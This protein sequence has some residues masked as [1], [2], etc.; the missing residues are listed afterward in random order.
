MDAKQ[1]F[2]ETSNEVAV[3]KLLT[4]SVV[5]NTNGRLPYL[6]RVLNSLMRQ[7][8]E[9]F[10]VCVV[11]GPTQDGTL[12]YLDSLGDRI[13][14]APCEAFNLSVSRNVGIAISAGDIIA[15]I[16][17]DS[18]AEPEWLLDLVAAYDD[19]D[20]GAAGGFVYDHTGTTFQAGYVTTN[21][22]GY[23]T[24]WAEPSPH[25]NFPLSADYPHL[26][27]TNCSFRRSALLEI[28]GF[29]NEFEYFLDETD[30]C[31]RLNDAGYSILQLSNGFVHHKY[32]PSHMRDERRIV[33]SWYPLI[34]NRVY[35]GIRNG[36]RHHS[37]REI[38]EA[39]LQDVRSW[40][41]SIDAAAAEGIYSQN[42]IDRFTAEADQAVQD[43][44]TRGYLAPSRL[45]DELLAH[46]KS[47]FKKFAVVSPSGS[48]KTFCFVTQDYP[49]DQNGGIARNISQL[50]RTLAEAGH[51]VHVLTKSRGTSTVDY[52]D[53]AWV[54]RVAI[55]H[56]VQ[57]ATSPI[58]PL[59]VPPHIWN[60]GQT[61][62]EEVNKI[63]KKRRVDVVYCPL[64]DCEPLA[65]VLDGSLPLIV[66]LQTTMKF[67][68]DSQ[69]E[70]AS[71]QA[72]MR[73]YGLPIIA[74]EELILKNAKVLHGNSR[75][76]VRDIEEKYGWSLDASKIYYSPHG[77]EDWSI[78]G[79][80]KGPNDAT[81]VHVLFVGRLESRKGI[82]VLLQA[83]P[84]I[85]S[86]YP[87]TVF[88]IVGDDAILK[89]DGSSY[90]ED[91]LAQTKDEELLEKVI[92]HGK[93]GEDI[94]RRFYAGCDIFVAPSRYESFGLVFLEAMMF[95]KPVIG[96]N[97]GGGPEVVTE[98]VSGF[99]VNP[100]DVEGLAQSL[101]VL[102]ANAELR[103]SMGRSAR[104]DY[105]SRFTDQVMIRD[106][107]AAVEMFFT[108]PA[109]QIQ[110]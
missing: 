100:G 79:E 38:I 39:G 1:F 106:M 47:A 40:E 43:A 37:L 41:R 26:L 28:G 88:D 21:R 22:L 20:V 42:D 33:K 45:T 78:A 72:W 75:A 19:E 93:V 109:V 63:Q 46:H 51:Q 53:G 95:G 107:Y 35:F 4:V 56:F 82:D 94:L 57:P 102:L 108:N 3:S 54:H 16:D 50:A 77:M 70:K 73:Q 97:A 65:F 15:F 49:P 32:A 29:D 98:G 59:I 62:L 91:F 2:K 6:K 76:I 9:N 110:E 81:A 17:D 12:S 90:K 13:K 67:W 87:N 68:L 92:F 52:E 89:P 48:K 31:C 23:A 27:G 104:Q 85:L 8:Y 7:V 24:N 101:E 36:L 55:R 25:L 61:M 10:E 66:A 96:C 64:W 44:V 69:P 103:A 84:L 80:D 71:D 58:A 74:M 86:K 11:Y 83:I 30:V 18:V 105:E 34:K 60:Y 14:S 99:L 5:I